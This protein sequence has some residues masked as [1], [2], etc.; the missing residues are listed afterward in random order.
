MTAPLRDR[1]IVAA[2]LACNH[3]PDV[4]DWR[5]RSR[6]SSPLAGR[7]SSGLATVIL[8]LVPR[9]CRRV[10]MYDA[11]SLDRSAD[12][13]DKPEDGA[14]T[15]PLRRRRDLDAQPTTRRW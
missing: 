15:R 4:G 14:A 2:I 3:P 8:G 6:H 5:K 1:S 12:P 9:I 11:I 13:R 10:R 7:A